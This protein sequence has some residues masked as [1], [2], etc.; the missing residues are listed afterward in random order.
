MNPAWKRDWRSCSNRGLRLGIT[1]A[2]AAAVAD[3][4]LEAL[5][6]RKLGGLP[7]PAAA[8]LAVPMAAAMA[9]R[10][11]AATRW[12]LAQA[13]PARQRAGSSLAASQGWD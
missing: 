10:L 5:A 4:G 7:G 8:R 3:W 11:P 13:S 12:D 6:I 2:T 1:Q 9:A